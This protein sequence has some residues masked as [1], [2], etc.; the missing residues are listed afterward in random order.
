MSAE[1]EKLKRGRAA[2]FAKLKASM[3]PRL[4]SHKNTRLASAGCRDTRSLL[5]DDVALSHAQVLRNDLWNMCQKDGEG[6]QDDFRFITILHAV[7][8]PL[9]DE[10]L[11]EALH[12]KRKLRAT[13]SETG[14]RCLGAVEFEIVNLTLLRKIKSRSTDETRKLDVLEKLGGRSVETGVLVHF[15]GVLDFGRSKVD[16][17]YL[18]RR[19]LETEDWGGSAYQVEIKQLYATKSLRENLHR[20]AA[21]LT[22]G[23]NETLRY[24]PG[25]GRDPDSQL[26]AQIW[27]GPSGRADHGAE[28]IPDERGMTIGE[29]QLLDQLW[30]RLMKTR[31]DD[32]GYIVDLR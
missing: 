2:A 27:R 9:C 6:S 21:Y 30:L 23:G 11:N 7:T 25:F 24:N 10:A 31:D 18:R 12:L 19:L 5:N 28:T 14:I 29:I 1:F 22:K 15:H 26:D 4:G 17:E 13:L 32:R 8:P 3:R 20:I 16:A